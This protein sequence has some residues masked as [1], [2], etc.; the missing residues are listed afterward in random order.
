MQFLDGVCVHMCHITCTKEDVLSCQIKAGYQ[1]WGSSFYLQSHPGAGVTGA[2]HYTRPSPLLR[3][4]VW[5][6]DSK[7]KESVYPSIIWGSEI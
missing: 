1:L 2:Y 7:L 4:F 6:S 5:R 3:Y